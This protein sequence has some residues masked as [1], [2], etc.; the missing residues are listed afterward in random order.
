[1]KRLSMP[2]AAA[3]ALVLA[4]AVLVAPPAAAQQA[5]AVLRDFQLTGDFVLVVDGQEQPK[6]EIYKSELVPA[7][8]VIAD[9]LASPT[10]VLPRERS[11]Q[12]VGFMK[13]LKRGD[14]YADVMADANLNPVGSFTLD[15]E[16]VVFSVDGESVRLKPRPYLIGLQGLHDMLDSNPDYRRKA[17]AYDP[18]SAAVAALEKTDKAVRVRI[19]FGSWCPFCKQY[20]PNALKVAEELQGSK[21][22]FEFYGLPHAFNDEP[23]AKRD[24]V[25]GV[26]TGI[27]YVDG[28]EVGR[29]TT[30]DWRAPEE[31]LRRLVASS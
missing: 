17:A 27:V 2:P 18:D 11:V 1:M 31:A 14:G 29:I 13:V 19:Y 23:A 7:L 15:G 20:V 10:L 12:T 6:A 21:V 25:N 16:D 3:A 8:M 28:K 24:G 30:N 26:P 22:D 4:L 5:D 9:K